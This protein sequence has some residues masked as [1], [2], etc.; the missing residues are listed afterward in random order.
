MDF[1]TL[2]A[3][4]P[5]A[6]TIGC[7]EGQVRKL[8]DNGKLP[9]A[10]TLRDGTRLY[11]PV[12]VA[13]FAIGKALGLELEEAADHRQ[14]IQK[15]AEALGAC[16]RTQ[17]SSLLTVAPLLLGDNATTRDR[18]EIA[19]AIVKAIRNDSEDTVRKLAVSTNVSKRR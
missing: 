15:Y 4:T 19:T 2:I 12:V 6:R 13:K 16:T 10:A 1:S 3:V 8:T 5:S 18:D 11:D 17:L 9:A 7:S 14:I